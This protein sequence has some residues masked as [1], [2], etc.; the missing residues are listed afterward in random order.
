MFFCS[1]N[2]YAIPTFTYNGTPLE[3]D[4]QFKYLGITLTRDRSMHISELPKNWKEPWKLLVLNVFMRVWWNVGFVIACQNKTQCIQFQLLTWL[5]RNTFSTARTQFLLPTQTWQ[6]SRAVACRPLWKCWMCLRVH[7]AACKRTLQ[8]C[9]K[10]YS[11][12][13]FTSLLYL[14]AGNCVLGIVV[15][16]P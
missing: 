9:K 6:Q 11:S 13:L 7:A 1:R 4:T 16:K 8:R 12:T 3:L 5:V 14:L 10:S 15:Y 2:T